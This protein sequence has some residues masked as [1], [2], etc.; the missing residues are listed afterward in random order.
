MKERTLDVGFT[1][2]FDLARVF[3]TEQQANW[4]VLSFPNNDSFC[5]Y[6]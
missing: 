1:G 6:M 2:L 4:S 3:F 5:Q